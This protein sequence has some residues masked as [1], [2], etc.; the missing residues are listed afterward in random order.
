MSTKI[1][2]KIKSMSKI[3]IVG[4]NGSPHLNGTTAKLVKNFLKSSEK[5]GAKTQLINLGK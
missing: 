1:K 2:N 4:I 5:F 3:F